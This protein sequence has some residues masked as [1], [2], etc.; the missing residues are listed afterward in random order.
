MMVIELIK[1][2]NKVIDERY[3]KLIMLKYIQ[4]S[5]ILLTFLKC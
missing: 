2:F 1:I 5:I 4:M 3:K